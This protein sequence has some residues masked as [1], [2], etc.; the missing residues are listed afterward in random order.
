MSEKDWIPAGY[1][2][3][4]PTLRAHG[5]ERL[6]AFLQAVFEA[7]VPHCGKDES[8]RINHAEVRIGQGVV[9]V[10]EA[11]GAWPAIAASL[12]VFVPDADAAYRRALEAGATSLYEPADMPYGERSG[13]VRDEFGNEWFIST[14]TRGAGRGYY[15]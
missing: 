10:S 14:F 5:A 7:E 15:D 11:N 4:V 2:S 6:L 9:E 1:P 12:H 3:V 13:G 8:G